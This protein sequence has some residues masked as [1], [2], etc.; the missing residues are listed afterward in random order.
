MSAEI[1]TRA[2]ELGLELVDVAGNFDT[3]SARLNGQALLFKGLKDDAEL[4]REANRATV[5]S[6]SAART[7]AHDATERVRESQK[8]L[9]ASLGG[10]SDLV[11]WIDCVGRQMQE[12]VDAVESIAHITKQVESIAAST[13]ML[14][15]N[16]TIEAART[17]EAGRGF[18]IIAHSIGDLSK[19]TIDAAGAIG[20]TIAALTEQ[21]RSVAEQGSQASRRAESAESDARSIGG[22]IQ[23]MSTTVASIDDRVGVI[24]ATAKKDAELVERLVDTM[25]NLAGGV[26]SS[27]TELEAA[28]RRVNNLLGRVEELLG[29]TARSGAETVDTPFVRLATEAARTAEQLFSGAL[30][31]GQIS[32]ADLFDEQYQ[33]VPGSNPVQYLTR[34]TAL[35]ERLL[36]ERLE[37][38]LNADSRAAFVIVADRNGYVPVHN[39][40]FSHPQGADPVWNAAHSRNR[41]IFDDRTGLAAARNTQPFLLQTYRRDM[42][43]GKFVLMKDMAVPIN[44]R[45]RHWGASRVG[46]R[47]GS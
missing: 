28:D 32:E 37:G 23:S 41:R 36:G 22:S 13:R 39:K 29:L 4:M 1:A 7:A 34:F 21:I 31:R 46:Y 45:G 26:A 27:S 33:Q 3:L 15:L 6:A 44:V 40:V 25:A 9:Q 10:V 20:T 12:L 47:V 5:G 43:D 8:A 18:T 38:F 19:Q 30:D 16:A 35:M 42:G 14:A 2:G 17:G 24:A 11:S